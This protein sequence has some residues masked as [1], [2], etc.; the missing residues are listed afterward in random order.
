M[1]LQA[2]GAISLAQIAAEFGLS[3]SAPFPSSFYGLGGAP[4]SGA[5]SF[6]NF[7]GRSAAPSVTFTPDGGTYD[8]NQLGPAE[9]TLT[10]SQAAVWTYSGTGSATGNSVTLPSGGSGTSITFTL[11]PPGISGVRS[12]TWTVTGTAAGV[13]RNFTIFLTAEA[14]SGV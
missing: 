14:D 1:T 5:L 9:F 8:V 6:A 7:Y 10:C 2:S 4:G 11:Q 13:T 12:R 3:A